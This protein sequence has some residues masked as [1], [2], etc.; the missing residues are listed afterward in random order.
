MRNG[1]IEKF[2]RHILSSIN[3][4]PENHAVY[5]I[6]SKNT[7]YSRAGHRWQY[8]T[9]HA[10]C[11]LDNQGYRHTLIMCNNYCLSTTKMVTRT[12]LKFMLYYINSLVKSYMGITHF[13]NWLSWLYVRRYPQSCLTNLKCKYL[14]IITKS[15]TQFHQANTTQYLRPKPG[16]L[17]CRWN[18]MAHGDAREGKWKGN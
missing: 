12:C 10:P 14:L 15:Y 9:A 2:E 18:V 1:D 13:A 6:M 5:E 11:M 3:F 17:N 7:V 4:L 16:V 8:N